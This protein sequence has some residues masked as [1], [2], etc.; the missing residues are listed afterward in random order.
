MST[1]RTA[2]EIPLDQKIADEN[3]N[4]TQV[5]MEALGKIAQAAS[6]LRDA[7]DI[8]NDLDSTAT[9]SQLGTAWAELR[10]KLQEI[11]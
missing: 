4:I 7:A 11:A 6:T 5:W 8:M 1:P 2:I 9:A 10:T 3:G